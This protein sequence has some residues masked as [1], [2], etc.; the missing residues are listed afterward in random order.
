LRGRANRIAHRIYGQAL[1]QGRGHRQQRADV[2]I[3]RDRGLI[4]DT[5]YAT[6]HYHEDNGSFMDD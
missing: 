6:K 3:K 4:V 1:H 5:M 2:W